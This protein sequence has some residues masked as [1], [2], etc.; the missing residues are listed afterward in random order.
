MS[1][2]GRGLMLCDLKGGY[3][4]VLPEGAVDPDAIW[5]QSALTVD[6]GDRKQGEGV[7]YGRDGRSLFASSE[8][9]NSPLYVIT[10]PE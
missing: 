1:P 8:R 5:R 2:D 10:R 9:K 6:L 7:S 4:L 3:E